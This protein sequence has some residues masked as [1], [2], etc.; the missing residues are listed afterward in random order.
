MEFRAVKGMNDILPQELSRW[1]RLERTF[2]RVV[3]RYGYREVRTPVL[4]H[5]DVFVRSIGVA[6]DIVEKVMFMIEALPLVR[7][8]R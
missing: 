2:Q 6:T 5:T 1:Q 7:N 3:E 4:E 8:C